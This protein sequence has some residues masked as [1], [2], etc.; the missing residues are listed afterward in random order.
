MRPA[1]LFVIAL[2]SRASKC[3]PLTPQLQRYYNKAN[4]ACQSFDF[5][6]ETASANVSAWTISSNL[7]RELFF[8]VD[9]NILI[10]ARTPCRGSRLRPGR[11]KVY[12]NT[13]KAMKGLR[14]LIVAY[15]QT[16][17]FPRSDCKAPAILLHTLSTVTNHL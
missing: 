7:I 6:L 11:D 1:C 12:L 4:I 10:D 15:L 3:Y 13:Q 17:N 14:E 5:R 8:T 2:V 16:R 9:N